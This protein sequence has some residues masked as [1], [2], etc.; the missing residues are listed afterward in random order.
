LIK[1]RS[2]PSSTTTFTVN[3]TEK[4]KIPKPINNINNNIQFKIN[5]YTNKYSKQKKTITNKNQNLTLT[6][7]HTQP[8]KH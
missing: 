2:K 6:S 3:K 4:K 8:F 7:A 1:T 5:S